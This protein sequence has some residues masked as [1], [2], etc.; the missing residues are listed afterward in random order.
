MNQKAH[1]GGGRS[2]PGGPVVKTSSFH[3]MSMPS[4]PDPGTKIP[5]AKK[6]SGCGGGG[7]GGQKET[8]WA[9]MVPAE[10]EGLMGSDLSSFTQ[11][12][13]EDWTVF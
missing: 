13:L 2:F 3:G 7:G 6:C 1:E 10:A 9:F 12:S 5:H 8:S 11:L 4:I